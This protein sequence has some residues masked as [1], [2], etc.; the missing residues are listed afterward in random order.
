MGI[1]G[2][3]DFFICLF[4]AFFPFLSFFM[5]IY[6]V[7]CKIDLKCFFMEYKATI[8]NRYILSIRS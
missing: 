1:G 4:F 8:T 6:V 7:L 5:T 3:G 2:G